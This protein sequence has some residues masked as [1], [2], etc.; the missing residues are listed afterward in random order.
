MQQYGKVLNRKITYI[1]PKNLSQNITLFNRHIIW[2]QVSFVR[3]N[4]HTR[5]LLKRASHH[6]RFLTCSTLFFYEKRVSSLRNSIRLEV[7]Q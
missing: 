2:Y 7:M 1:A 6:F 4:S 5:N 3:I